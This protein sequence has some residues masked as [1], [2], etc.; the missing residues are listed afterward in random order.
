MDLPSSGGRAVTS[1]LEDMAFVRQ[2]LET[3]VRH[4]EKEVI[5]ATSS[6]GG[7]VGSNA[8]S[9]LEAGTR[10]ARGEKGGIVYFVFIAAYVVPLGKSLLDMTP[11][12]P[13]ILAP[14]PT[15]ASRVIVVGPEQVFYNDVPAAVSAPWVARLRP[16]AVA[17]FMSKMTAT[18]EEGGVVPCTYVVCERDG[19]VPVR[20]QEGMFEAGREVSGA[21]W[22]LERIGTGHSPWLSDVEGL[23]ALLEKVAG[24]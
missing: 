2:E 23:V 14:D 21:E 18:V 5:V 19:A 3:L 1:H 11:E 24:R 16:Q 4:E 10:R 20:Q 9:G 22:R 15:D 13:A 7:M 8:V 6:Y 17:T 12:P